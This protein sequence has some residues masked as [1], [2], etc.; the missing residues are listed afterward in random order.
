MGRVLSTRLA[1]DPIVATPALGLACGAD[2]VLAAL[3]I[4]RWR[5]RALALIQ[6]LVIAGYTA[7]ATLLWPALWAQPLGALFKN[8]PILAAVLALGAIEEER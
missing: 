6:V 7:V 2:L 8:V 3:L 4:A 5:P 1:L